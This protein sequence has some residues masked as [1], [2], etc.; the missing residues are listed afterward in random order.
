LELLAKLRPAT[1]VTL[2]SPGAVWKFDDSGSNLGTGWRNN[3]FADAKWSSGAARLGYGGDGEVTTL[4]RTNSGGGTNIT[5]YFRKQ[6]Y[7]PNPAAVQSL[8]ARMIRDDGA[9]VYLNSS[10]VWRDNMPAG[11]IS[12]LTPASATVSGAEETSWITNTLNPSALI[13]GWNTLAAELHQV[14]NTSSDVGFDFSLA[15]MSSIESPTLTA[16]ASGANVFL[17]WP[18]YASYFGIDGATNLVAPVFWSE[19]TNAPVLSNN[20]WTVAIPI[21]TNGSRFYRLQTR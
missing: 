5:F 13:A 11:T 19:V 7:I 9:V 4:T 3:S 16:A 15:A 21:A 17:S 12:Y 1:P 8:T 10:E 14:S 6:F 18:A 20:V 2:I